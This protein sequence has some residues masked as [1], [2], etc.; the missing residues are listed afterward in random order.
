MKFIGLFMPAIVSLMI[1]NRNNEKEDWR[2]P[3]VFFRYGIYVLVNVWLTEGIII[4]VL[5]LSGV[6]EEALT[7]FPF[8][9]KY[10]LIALAMAVVVPYVEEIIRKY[11]SIGLTVE[12]Y[13]EKKESSVEGSK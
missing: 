12:I 4:Y 6:I 8:F 2:M 7:S 10:T 3:Q 13:D 9:L 1:R 11:I 5:G